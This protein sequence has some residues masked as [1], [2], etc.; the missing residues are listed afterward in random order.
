MTYP[1]DLLRLATELADLDPGNPRQAC[2]RRSVST[3]Y[4]AL[5]HLLI[6]E[7]T[8][9]WAHPELRSDVGRVFEHGKM[10]T[11]SSDKSRA[12]WNAN[13][14]RTLAPASAQ[15]LIVV[16]AF[17]QLQQERHE[18]D[19][20]TGKDW[21]RAEVRSLIGIASDAFASW[22]LIRSEPEAQSYLVSLFGRRRRFE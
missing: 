9:N 1:D 14:T 13:K 4:Y 8:L 12:L 18:A 22:N 10:K 16:D 21:N 2:L 3:A 20:D 11:A 15:L 17:V 6:A 5:F 7:A 19:Y